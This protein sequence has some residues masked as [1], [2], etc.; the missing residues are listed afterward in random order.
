MNPVDRIVTNMESPADTNMRRHK[1]TSH[2]INRTSE[3]YHEKETQKKQSH[4]GFGPEKDPLTQT[5]CYC[6]GHGV[7][8]GTEV[9]DVSTGPAEVFKTLVT[10]GKLLTKLCPF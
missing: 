4:C 9:A 10:V 1:N 8:S 6:R 3:Q 5:Y 2:N 7:I